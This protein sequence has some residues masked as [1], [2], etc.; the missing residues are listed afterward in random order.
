MFVQHQ[1]VRLTVY[2]E[3]QLS[4]QVFPC[5]ITRSGVGMTAKDACS[6]GF[7]GVGGGGQ[8]VMG[9]KPHLSFLFVV[10]FT[11]PRDLFFR[12]H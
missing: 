2:G 12:R 6:R 5:R 4:A 8:G 7:R 11:I 9:F 3:V 10:S 1:H